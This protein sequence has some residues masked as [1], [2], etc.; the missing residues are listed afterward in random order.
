MATTTPLQW[1]R[2]VCRHGGVLAA[3]GLLM[4]L[5]VGLVVGRWEARTAESP[6]PAAPSGSLEVGQ[7]LLCPGTMVFQVRNDGA[8]PVTIA[9]VSIDDA[10]W[11]FTA[12]PSTTIAPHRTASATL[13]YSWTAGVAYELQFISS[14]G[15]T[16]VTDIDASTTASAPPCP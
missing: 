16:Y 4:G 6:P 11:P 14:T 8:Q 13:R 12:R 1:L 15:A 10:F 7:T 3:F 2:R 9:Q 5:A